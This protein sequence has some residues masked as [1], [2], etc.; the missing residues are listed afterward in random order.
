MPAHLEAAKAGVEP[1][2]N[3]AELPPEGKTVYPLLY[4]NAPW[5]AGHRRRN[6]AF[7]MAGDFGCM[8]NASVDR[9]R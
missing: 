7:W 4:G 9:W 5:S 6:D 2:V 1:Y 8:A 3:M